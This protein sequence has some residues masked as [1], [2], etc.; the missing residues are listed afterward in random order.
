MPC[1]ATKANGGRTRNLPEHDVEKW[2]LFKTYCMQDVEV[3]RGI[4][5]KLEQYPMTE[6]ELKLWYLDQQINDYG[7]RVDRGM[8]ENA[9]RCDEVYQK[10]LVEEATRLTGLDNPNSPAQ[11]KGW[12]QDKHNIQVE[13]LSKDAVAELLEEAEEPVVKRALELRLE[14]ARTSIKKYE[15]MQRAVGADGRIRGL[16]Q[17]YGA[18]RTGRWAGRLVQIHNLPRNNMSDLHLARQLLKA[19]EYEVL[20]LLFESVPDVLSQLTRTAFIPSPGCRFIVSD[21]SAIEARVIAWLAGEGWVLDTFK[22][23]GKI[24]E[25]TASRMFGAWLVRI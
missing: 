4:R 20:E 22:S 21:F 7:V 18:N 24:Y 11:L 10:K 6:K 5:R 3:E 16:L 8:V 19:G 17:Y 23:H 2:E 9:I 25:M 14:M 13:S 12:L 1:K 15:A